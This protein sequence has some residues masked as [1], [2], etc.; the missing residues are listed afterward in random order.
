MLGS[1]FVVQL[2]TLVPL[3]I[4]VIIDKVISQRSLDTLQARRA[5]VAVTIFEGLLGSLRTFMFADTTNRI[6]MRLGAEVIDHLLRLPVGYF[7][8]RPVESWAPGLPNSRRSAPLHRGSP[9][10]DHRCGPLRSTSW[11]WR[12]TA[13]CLR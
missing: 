10:H 8:R 12:S 7:D 4:Q 3:L 2:F 1:S 11:R 5:L 9:H 13:G 6:D